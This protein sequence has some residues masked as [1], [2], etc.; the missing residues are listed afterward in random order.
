MGPEARNGLS[1]AS[2][3]CRLRDSHSWVNSP[4][5]PLR[6]PPA[7]SSARSI[8]RLRNRSRFAPVPAASTPQIRCRF[9]NL[10]D[11]LH[12]PPPLPIGIVTS[13]R[14]K[15]AAELPACQP[16][17]RSARFPFA[18]RRRSIASFG[19]G[20]SFPVRYF[21]EACCSSNLLEPSPICPEGRLAVKL[22][23]VC[24]NTFPQV[25]GFLISAT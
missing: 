18:P 10:R 24:R 25:C 14:I 9:R 19:C 11:R 22:F 6:S 3:G 2:N 16:T 21:P 20:S 1:L 23:F 8:F 15:A 4:G 13:P 7:A 17:F 12:S 5:L